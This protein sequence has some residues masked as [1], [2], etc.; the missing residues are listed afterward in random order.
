MPRIFCIL[1]VMGV[2][3]VA[4]SQTAAPTRPQVQSQTQTPP[5]PTSES[6]QRAGGSLLRATVS[7]NPDPNQAKLASVSY[8]SVPEAVPRTLKKHDLVTIVVREESEYK[9]AGTTD[10]QHSA[11]FDAKMANFVGIRLKG[12]TLSGVQPQT[13]PEL[14]F[15]AQRD[16]KNAADVDRSDSMILRI[17]AEVIDVKPNGTLVLQAKQHIKNDEEDQM[18][19]L[20]GTCR[21]DDIGPDNT[22]LS[23]Q[24][25]DTDLSKVTKGAV[26]DTNKRGFIPK[27]L[28]LVNP[29]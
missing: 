23:T 1:V 25:F 26:H 3:S 6:I 7:S 17:T 16:L 4:W 5:P 9:A 19:I 18:V 29:F 14:N 13:A 20:S 2:T 11:D 27:L 12:L 15:T 10:L 22:I 21:V 28:D 24:M 8:F